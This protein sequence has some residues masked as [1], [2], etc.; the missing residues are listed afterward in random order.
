[1]G[2]VSAAANGL[3][4][5][6]ETRE[7]R[8]TAGTTET[9]TGESAAGTLAALVRPATFVLEQQHLSDVLTTFR[10]ER[11]HLALVVGEYGQVVGLLTLEDVLE[12]LVGEIQDEYDVSEEAP[13]AHRPDGSWLVAGTEAY[14]HVRVVVGLPPI[15]PAAERGQYATLPGLQMLRLERVPRVGDRVRLSEGDGWEAEVATMDGRRVCQVLLRRRGE[16]V[17]R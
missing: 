7:T 1:M 4:R 11:A 6:R 15:P 3:A 5:T 2:A 12:E 10:R 16:E 17:A 9:A 14:E 13:I 8:E